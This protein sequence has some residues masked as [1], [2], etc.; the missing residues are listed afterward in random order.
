MLITPLVDLAAAG[1]A[2]AQSFPVF[3]KFAFF[4]HL[5]R[6]FEYFARF[7]GTQLAVPVCL[8]SVV[9]TLERLKV[10]Q[11]C[12]F[13][14]INKSLS[15]KCLY[16]FGLGKKWIWCFLSSQAGLLCV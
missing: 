6:C 11:R 15:Y 5:K 12:I 8:A 7:C 13:F 10:L 3:L 14:S 1:F 2:S 4:G 16:K 9:Q